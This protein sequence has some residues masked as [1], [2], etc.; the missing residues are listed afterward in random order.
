M[1][2]RTSSWRQCRNEPNSFFLPRLLRRLPRCASERVSHTTRVRGPHGRCRFVHASR[3]CREQASMDGSAARPFPVGC[4]A[5]TSRHRES[6]IGRGRASRTEPLVGR[7]RR[8]DGMSE[9]RLEQSRRQSP[10]GSLGRSSPRTSYQCASHVEA[11]PETRGG[12][13]GGQTRAWQGR[14]RGPGCRQA[15]REARRAL[16]SSESGRQLEW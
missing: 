5:A 6:S 15:L 1:T 2:T 4:R 14:P 7:V 3:A 8:S 10:D 11:S 9:S 12:L 13:P 16:K